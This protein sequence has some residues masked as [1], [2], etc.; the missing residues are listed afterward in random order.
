MLFNF[1]TKGLVASASAGADNLLHSGALRLVAWMRARLWHIV[2]CW[3]LASGAPVSAQTE[4]LRLSINIDQAMRGATARFPEASA[5]SNNPSLVLEGSTQPEA[6]R[7]ALRIARRAYEQAVIEAG[8]WKAFKMYLDVA[9][10]VLDLY[11]VKFFFIPLSDA[12][13]IALIWS[14]SETVDE[15]SSA[16]LKYLLEKTTEIGVVLSTDD[17]VAAAAA[18]K[19]AG[20]VFDRMNATLASQTLD[21]T[22]DHPN[23]GAV[24]IS[25][26]FMRNVDGRLEVRFSV[27]G[28]CACRIPDGDPVKLGAFRVYGSVAVRLTNA[29]DDQSPEMI[30]EKTGEF[31][32]FAENQCTPA[33]APTPPPPADEPTDTRPIVERICLRRCDDELGEVEAAANSEATA[34]LKQSSAGGM[35]SPLT[36]LRE[37]DRRWID[38][39]VAR[40]TGEP[41]PQTNERGRLLRVLKTARQQLSNRN[42]EILPLEQE[43]AD[44]RYGLLVAR[45]ALGL[46]RA[47]VAA[48]KRECYEQAPATDRPP[49]IQATPAVLKPGADFEV[50][51]VSQWGKESGAWVGMHSPATMPTSGSDALRDVI[52]RRDL[53]EHV[54]T[55]ET[56]IDGTM[57]WSA[58][59]E[60]GRYEMRLYS[61]KS[62]DDLL[63]ARATFEV[64][65]DEN[66]AVLC[67]ETVDVMRAIA[68]YPDS[69]G[70]DFPPP[71]SWLS[72]EDRDLEGVW[73]IEVQSAYGGSATYFASLGKGLESVD[74][75]N[76]D[77][78]WSLIGEFRTYPVTPFSVSS[79]GLRTVFYDGRDGQVMEVRPSG[80]PNRL[81]GQWVFNEER[82]KV[83]WQKIEPPQIASVWIDSN[84][85]R[86]DGSRITDEV[87]FGGRPGVLELP[88]GLGCG[89]MQGNCHRVYLAISGTNLAGPNPVWLDPA[90]HLDLLETRFVNARNESSPTAGY[91]KGAVKDQSATRWISF[92]FMVRDGIE[93]GRFT[94]WFGNTPIPIEIRINANGTE[95]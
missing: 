64:R 81:A 9:K 75:R 17:E 28:D 27:S 70:S 69:C 61:G 73:R 48:C 50:Q 68:L 6:A 90:S 13:D 83:T 23:C 57:R 59:Y 79:G 63:V 88:E 47:R 54:L 37:S 43:L 12:V 89:G 5:I 39:L 11:G 26:W 41:P 29:G 72:K 87:A 4:D 77:G 7:H 1:V 10:E 62:A 45:Q 67:D 33:D 2:L 21:I 71:R 78:P 55:P 60:P 3:L 22:A 56:S 80:Q 85:S 34:R 91:M 51:F 86:A 31:R 19:V 94:L 20:L 74:Y 38:D 53:S 42:R 35:L 18:D 66:R 25:A 58:P 36:R 8:A 32:V 24:P 30:L 92:Q 95:N 15:F 84:L 44:A 93:S 82:A 65:P 46:A 40:L 49:S 14:D 16:F 76:P 52:E